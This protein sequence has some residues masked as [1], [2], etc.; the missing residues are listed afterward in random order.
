MKLSFYIVATV[1]V[2]QAYGGHIALF[3]RGNCQP[4]FEDEGTSVLQIAAENEIWC[5]PIDDVFTSAVSY[6]NTGLPCE[7]R[8]YNSRSCSL[9]PLS[10][11]IRTYKPTGYY[12]SATGSSG[13]HLEMTALCGPSFSKRDLGEEIVSNATEA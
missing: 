13:R 11:T 4:L 3:R 5:V 10:Y 2:S 6:Y 9:Q 7:F 12:L 8:L 1:A